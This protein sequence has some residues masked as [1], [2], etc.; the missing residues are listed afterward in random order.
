MFE[1]I[2]WIS[3]GIAFFCAIL[4]AID[5][6]RHPQKMWIMNIVWPVTALYFSVFA[7][8]GYF[9]AGRK[10]SKSAMAKMDEERH[11]GETDQTRR[12][13]TA[14][15]TAISDSHC[16]AGCTLG[17]IVAEFSLFALGWTLLGKTLYAEYAGDLLLAWLLGIAF[18]YFTIKPMRNLSAGQ[19]LVAAVKA[20][21]LSILSFEVGLFAWMSLTFFVFFPHPHLKPTQ[22]GYWFMMQIGMIL[23][24]FTSYP[25]NRWLVKKG[26]KEAMG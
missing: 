9:R 12:D 24:F 2:S 21:T 13:P 4:I 25:V 23:G 26:W 14:T 16:G 10:M 15:Q 8:W 1:T 6:L 7:V 18:Q 17:D 20:D 5:E 11:K 19:G 22:A 3:L